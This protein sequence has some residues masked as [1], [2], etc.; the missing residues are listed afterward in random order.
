MIDKIGQRCT[1][2]YACVS[3]C[4]KQCIQM[5]E[6]KEGFWYPQIDP[7][8]CVHCERCEEVLVPQEVS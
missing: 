7:T 5:V 4:P 3:A 2:C 8:A 1:G 6:D